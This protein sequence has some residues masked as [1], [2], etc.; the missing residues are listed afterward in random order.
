MRS[1]WIV[2]LG[3]I[4]L[5]AAAGSASAD[6]RQMRSG[7]SQEEQQMQAGQ[8]P[9]E[10]QTEAARAA[11]QAMGGQQP[12]QQKA[13]SGT[14]IEL[15]AGAIA[16]QPDPYYGKK[17][18][19]ESEVE[20]VF[21]PHTFTL[22]EDAAFAGPDVLAFLPNPEPGQTVPED[23]NVIVTGTL[24]RFVKTSFERDYDWF[25]SSSLQ[26]D[27]LVRIEERPVIIAQSVRTPK[28]EELASTDTG[29][30]SVAGDAGDERA[31]RTED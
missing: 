25:D 27:L 6:D 1:R 9:T 2:T 5:F 29:A 15:T 14:P 11:S 24:T 13:A 4:A 8:Q 20:S 28:G 30:G 17:V 31:A 18:K 12:V 3:T 10:R 23:Q 19:V 22:D 26:P 21:N 16:K 7:T